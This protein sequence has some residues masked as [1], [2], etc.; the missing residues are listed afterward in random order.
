MTAPALPA[1]KKKVSLSV[2][3]REARELIWRYRGRL[4][5]GLAIMLVN[6]LAGLVLP[7]SSKFLIDRVLKNG[8]VRLLTPLAL[9]LI[10]V[11]SV[12]KVGV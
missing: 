12:Y 11:T 6:R 9:A 7:A 3:W 4:A 1:K 8:E 5:F 10:L 2:V